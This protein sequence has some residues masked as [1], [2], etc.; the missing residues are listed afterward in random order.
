MVTKKEQSSVATEPMDLGD[1]SLIEDI[2]K[3]DFYMSGDN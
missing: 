1:E 2:A 3:I